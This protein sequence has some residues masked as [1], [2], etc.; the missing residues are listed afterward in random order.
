MNDISFAVE[1]FGLAA[2]DPKSLQD[3]YVR[4][5]D[6]QLVWADESVPAYF[7]RLPGGLVFE[8]Y[9]AQRSVE[10]VTDNGVAGHRHLALRVES[11]E[12]AKRTLEERGVEFTEA[13]K[14][15]GGGGTVQFFADAEGNLIHL[16][17]RP[18]DS[19]F[20]NAS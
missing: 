17:E 8:I 7:V 5:L 2:N 16:V 6:G 3:W 20:A 10:D 9:P 13:P 18:A 11:I 4:V 1:H 19:A 12:T 15:A 14:P